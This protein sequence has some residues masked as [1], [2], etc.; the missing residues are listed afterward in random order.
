MPQILNDSGLIVSDIVIGRASALD[1]INIGVPN[2]GM[3]NLT[4]VVSKI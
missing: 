4:L 2:Q 3:G 1:I